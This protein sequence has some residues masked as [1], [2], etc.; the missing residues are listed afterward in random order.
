MKRKKKKKNPSYGRTILLFFYGWNQCHSL[1]F[2]YTLQL[3]PLFF[4]QYPTRKMSFFT[5]A[6][7]I[8]ELYSKQQYAALRQK[9]VAFGVQNFRQ[10]LTQQGVFTA[11]GCISSSRNP[12]ARIA[13]GEVRLPY[14]DQLTGVGFSKYLDKYLVIKNK[15]ELDAGWQDPAMAGKASMGFRHEFLLLR[16]PHW[17]SFNVLTLGL[18]PEQLTLLEAVEMLDEMERIAQEYAGARGWSSQLGLFFHCYPL[19]SIPTLYLHMVDLCHTGPSYTAQLHKTLQLSDVR[20]Q[21]QDELTQ[22]WKSMAV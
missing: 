4:F 13:Y 8:K 22:G 1:F 2:S 12:L 18:E 10:T 6:K 11:Q 16:S 21:L 20:A 7:E 15:P 14:P 19:N 17:S 5:E 3:F 9:L